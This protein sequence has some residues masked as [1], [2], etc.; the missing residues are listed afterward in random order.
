[1]AYWPNDPGGLVACG[2][3]ALWPIGL[4]YTMAYWPVAY[5]PIGHN[6]PIGYWPGPQP[7]G[8]CRCSGQSGSSTR[9][10]IH[11]SVRKTLLPRYRRGHLWL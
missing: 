8:A 9:I 11:V 5:W 2:P 10:Y 7:N 4:L 1:M 6:G 3:V